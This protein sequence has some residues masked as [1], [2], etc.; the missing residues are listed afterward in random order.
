M[1]RFEQEFAIVPQGARWTAILVCLAMTGVLASIF[2]LPGF[3]S[4]DAKAIAIMS[5][6]FLLTLLGVAFAG[7]FVLLIGYV[8]ADAGRRGMNQL[9]WT[10]LA[11]FIPNAIGLILYFLLRQPRL[12]PCPTCARPVRAEHA[13]CAGCGAPAR[14][15]CSRC[16]RPTQ[17]GWRNCAHCGVALETPPP[18]L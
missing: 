15:V 2:L 4:G 6:L 7:G 9:L 18:S 16:Q 11:I 14:R 12:L 1:S 3:A 13:Y 5:P 10:L 8:Y 17:A